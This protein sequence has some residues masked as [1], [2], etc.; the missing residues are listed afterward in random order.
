MQILDFRDSF[1]PYIGLIVTIV[2][3]AAVI[4]PAI[5][6]NHKKTLF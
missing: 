3:F 2:I 4:V 1:F 5:F 6:M